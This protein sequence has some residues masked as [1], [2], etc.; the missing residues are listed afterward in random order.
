MRIMSIIILLFLLG[1]FTIGISLQEGD[2]IEIDNSIDDGLKSVRNITLDIEYYENS[3][4]NMKGVVKILEEYI[5]FIGT[6]A[7]EIIRTGIHFGQD[8]PDYFEPDTLIMVMKW[9]II[10]VIV[11]LLAKPVGYLFIFIILF[12]IWVRE[13][14]KR[15]K[16]AKTNN[17]EKVMS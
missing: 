4:I 9:I 10:L 2:R 17:N 5:Q 8:N 1:A 11:G 14:L 3:S 13:I 7:F 15:R 12:F 6:F 16:N